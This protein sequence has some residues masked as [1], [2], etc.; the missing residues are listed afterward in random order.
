VLALFDDESRREY[1]RE[2]D[3][4]PRSF[5]ELLRAVLGL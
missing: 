1:E 2:H 4:D 3:V 5:D